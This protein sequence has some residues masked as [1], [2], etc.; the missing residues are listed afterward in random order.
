MFDRLFKKNK[1]K[2]EGS[3]G[4]YYLSSFSSYTVDKILALFEM[5]ADSFMFTHQPILFEQLEF[6]DSE[7]K[8]ISINGKPNFISKDF[9][10][11]SG[12]TIFAYRSFL[13]GNQALSQLHFINN[14]FFFGALTISAN[15][16][17]TSSAVN[18]LLSEKYFGGRGLDQAL[19]Y[20]VDRGRNKIIYENYVNITLKY[21]SGK[22][23]HRQVIEHHIDLLNSEMKD[24]EKK[25]LDKFSKKI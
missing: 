3:K 22:V 2:Q 8:C 6:G 14:E 15:D 9:R 13:L 10:G 4:E 17:N 24:Q 18:R 23:E 21:I 11:L 7:S 20:I 16:S 25:I 5:D 1:K 12:H 19:N